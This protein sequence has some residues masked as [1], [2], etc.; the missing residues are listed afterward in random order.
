MCFDAAAFNTDTS[1]RAILIRRMAI[2]SDDMII[3]C[4][5]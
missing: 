3:F 2:L 5:R 1:Q 4:V